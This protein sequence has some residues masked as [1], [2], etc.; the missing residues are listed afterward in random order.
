MPSCVFIYRT[1][2]DVNINNSKEIIPSFLWRWTEGICWGITQWCLFSPQSEWGWRAASA[3]SRSVVCHPQS[4]AASPLP[5]HRTPGQGP[6]SSLS[7]YNGSVV[8]VCPFLFVLSFVHGS[9][10]GWCSMIGCGVG[11]QHGC[12]LGWQQWCILKDVECAVLF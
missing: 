8:E 12:N 2:I 5:G 9:T 11:W 3:G 6:L 7:W 10:E 1:R 4:G